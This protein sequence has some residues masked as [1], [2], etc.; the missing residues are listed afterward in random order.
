MQRT[1]SSY[2]IGVDGPAVV[3]PARVAAWLEARAGLSGLRVKAR[4]IDP[5]VDAV[6]VAIRVVGLAWRDSATGSHVEP[7][8]EV[9]RGSS[10]WLSTGQAADLL[11]ITDR[12]VRLAISENR[13]PAQQV[14]G[15]YRI[16][17]ADV[18][19]YRAARAA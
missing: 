8:P 9:P 4:G 11:G 13:L 14:A 16:T 7:E 18:E 17:R 5:E 15:R 12:A 3:V 6:L 1:A 2:V 19:H 10:Q